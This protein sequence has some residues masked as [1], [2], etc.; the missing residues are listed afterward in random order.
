MH[1]ASLEPSPPHKRLYTFGANL[2]AEDDST[3]RMEFAMM[4][5]DLIKERQRA[6]WETGDYSMIGT[7]LQI[8][9]EELCDQADLRAGSRVLDMSQIP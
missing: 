3:H 9:S 4:D 5:F 7:T 6:A 2:A 1:L 8:V